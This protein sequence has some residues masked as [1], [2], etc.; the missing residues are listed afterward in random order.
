MTTPT[1][2]PVVGSIVFSTP[3]FQRPEDAAAFNA[4]RAALATAQEA[5]R[6]ATTPIANVTLSG[7]AEYWQERAQRAEADA[8]RWRFFASSKQTALMLGS[9]IDPFT[10]E[11]TKEKLIA[12]CN[13]LADAAI[14]AAIAREP[15]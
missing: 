15:K 14:D 2:T 6:R 4:L 9:N 3:T 10:E 12:E 5:L 7:D 11:I 8:E 13:Q 1:Q